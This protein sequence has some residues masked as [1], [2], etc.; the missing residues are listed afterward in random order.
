MTEERVLA[1]IPHLPEGLNELYCH[2]SMKDAAD[3]KR[4]VPGYQYREELVALLSPEV[5]QAL[6][7]NDITLTRFAGSPKA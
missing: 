1:L 4:G 3:M 2:P 5:R 7:D 6:A